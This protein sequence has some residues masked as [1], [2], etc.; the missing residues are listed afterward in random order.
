[1]QKRWDALS[2]K[3]YI[4]HINN[5]TIHIP[6]LPY[7]YITCDRQLKIPYFKQDR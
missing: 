4:T 7:Q 1:M 5:I 6:V 3:I 2:V